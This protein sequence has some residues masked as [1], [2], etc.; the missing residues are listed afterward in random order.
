MNTTEGLSVDEAL[1]LLGTWVPMRKVIEAENNGVW[2]DVT[3]DVIRG[4]IYLD[5]Y[6]YRL[7]PPAPKPP[8]IIDVAGEVNQYLEMTPVVIKSLTRDGILK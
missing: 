1:A 5:R 6:I 4:R 3:R 8:K 7:R 2:I